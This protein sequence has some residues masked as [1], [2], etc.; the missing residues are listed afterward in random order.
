MQI[1]LAQDPE[2]GRVSAQDRP[3]EASDFPPGERG[4]G[5]E[6]RALDV[7]AQTWTKL[8][9]ATYSPNAQDAMHRGWWKEALR[10]TA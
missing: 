4:S 7:P 9:R 2:T 6:C 10:A 3:F 1:W 5:W 8:L